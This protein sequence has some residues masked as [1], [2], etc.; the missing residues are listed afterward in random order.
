MGDKGTG[1]D[2]GGSAPAGILDL[3]SQEDNHGEDR[4]F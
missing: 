1:R 3:G 2:A 4:P